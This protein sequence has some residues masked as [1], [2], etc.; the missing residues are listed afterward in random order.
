MTDNVVGLFGGETPEVTGPI[1]RTY[2]LKLKDANTPVFQDLNGFLVTNGY[3]VCILEDPEDANTVMFMANQAELLYCRE[4]DE[5][6]D[7]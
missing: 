7:A 3:V 2:E 5:V 1:P 4:Q 6:T